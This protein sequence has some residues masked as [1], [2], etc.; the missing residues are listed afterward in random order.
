[1]PRGSVFGLGMIQLEVALAPLQVLDVE[2]S[3]E[4]GLDIVVSQTYFLQ[5]PLTAGLVLHRLTVQTYSGF[6]PN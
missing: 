3:F 1:M 2:S 5:F 6:P 4:A